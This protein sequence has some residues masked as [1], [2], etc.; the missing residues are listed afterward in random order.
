IAPML[1][2]AGLWRDAYLAGERGW[3]GRV[4]ELLKPRARKLADF[5]EHGRFFFADTVSYDPAAASKHLSVPDLA[6]HV[7]ALGEALALVEPFD[8]AA[9]ETA[10]RKVADTR[11]IKAAPL[12]HATRVA[13][14]GRAVS[15][16]LFEVVA[17]LGRSRT[18]SRLD[19]LERHLRSAV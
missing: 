6:T 4:I 3:M 8:A 7:R 11:G 12:I 1:Q 16:G 19:A 14:T 10:L 5:V 18:L 13:V 15:P 9:I 17:V 2:A